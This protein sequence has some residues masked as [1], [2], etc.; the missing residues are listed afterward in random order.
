MHSFYLYLTYLLGPVK[1]AFKQIK[2]PKIVLLVYPHKARY[3]KVLKQIVQ[4]FSEGVFS[5]DVVM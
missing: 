3:I 1:Y 4:F 5:G 2:N